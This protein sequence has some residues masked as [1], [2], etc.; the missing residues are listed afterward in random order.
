MLEAL[1]VY[2]A[3]GQATVITP[4]ILAGAMAPISVAG[5][6]VQQNAEVLAGITYAQIVHPG[7][8]VVYGSF[9]TNID[10]K[11]GAPV[12]GSAESQLALYASAQLSRRYQL[13]FRSGGMFTSA[14]LPD[15]Q[16]AYESMM[17]MLPAINAHTN[18]I[19]H[20]AGWLE[21]GL[22]AGYEK[23][24]LDDEVLGMIL[25]FLDGFEAF[26]EEGL[27]L[28][29]IRQVEAGGHHLGTDH[30]MRH[31]REAFH[32][33]EFFDYLD[34]DTWQQ[35]GSLPIEQVAAQRVEAILADVQAPPLDQAIEAELNRF[36]A[37]RKTEL[38]PG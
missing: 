16:A 21:N 17:T 3:A 32:R 8:P 23:F 11:T 1:A 19:L 29:S 35:A 33:P 2:A 5:T 27:A 10:L 6:V 25:R 31:F 36:V 4:F 22:T 18:V 26:D 12:F 28:E 14:K 15:S 13:P 9:M 30:T 38:S 7:A 37:S 34:L 24:L 20:A